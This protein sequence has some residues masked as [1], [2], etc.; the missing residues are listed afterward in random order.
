MNIDFLSKLFYSLIRMCI[1]FYVYVGN[2]GGIWCMQRLFSG[3]MCMTTC[4]MCL[5]TASSFTK[6]ECFYIQCAITHD[7]YIDTFPNVQILCSNGTITIACLCL[8]IFTILR[9]RSGIH[10]NLNICCIANIFKK[11]IC[12]THSGSQLR[13]R[14]LSF[15]V[16]WP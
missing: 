9:T 14:C 4:S 13:N 15:T 11:Y 8:H 6:S 3:F 5:R 16:H 7:S 1:I 10:K 12:I 2:I